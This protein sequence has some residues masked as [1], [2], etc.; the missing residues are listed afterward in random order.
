LARKPQWV[1]SS[2]GTLERSRGG[3]LAIYLESVLR[4]LQTLA[5]LET[6]LIGKDVQTLQWTLSRSRA[7]VSNFLRTKEFNLVFSCGLWCKWKRPRLRWSSVLHGTAAGN[8]S[9]SSTS[10]CHSWA[11][12]KTSLEVQKRGGPDAFRPSIR[13]VSKRNSTTKVRG[14]CL[15]C[16]APS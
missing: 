7:E 8:L 16:C 5:K 12:H 10:R 9:P 3:S 15:S 2:N 11:S 1:L 13:I 6:C 4:V 14:F